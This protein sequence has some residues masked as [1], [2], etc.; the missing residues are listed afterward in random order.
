MAKNLA[1]R[2]HKQEEQEAASATWPMSSPTRPREEPEARARTVGA[3][4][5]SP[6]GFPC[7]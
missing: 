4:S 5:I 1:A 7:A 6:L 2:L 3:W